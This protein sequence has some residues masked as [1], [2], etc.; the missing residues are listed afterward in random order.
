MIIETLPSVKNKVDED[1]IF[2]S[3]NFV[4][5]DLDFILIFGSESPKF[6]FMPERAL[7]S[8]KDGGLLDIRIFSN[9]IQTHY[10]PIYLVQVEGTALFY[11]ELCT[12]CFF[13]LDVVMRFATTQNPGKLITSVMTWIDIMSVLPFYIQV[14]K[15]ALTILCVF[16]IKCSVFIVACC[17]FSQP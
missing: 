16:A 1:D 6:I 4:F 3:V 17:S 10:S 5:H 9:L 11:A 7:F 13:T 12:T 14:L 2:G 8:C 15:G